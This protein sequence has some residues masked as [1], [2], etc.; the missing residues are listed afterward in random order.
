MLQS[1][2]KTVVTYEVNNMF[3]IKQ[4]LCKHD[5]KPS[6]EEREVGETL[7]WDA[8]PT[9][10]YE[11]NYVCEKCKKVKVSKYIYFR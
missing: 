10:E 8:K 4:R 6:G 11:Q 5:F 2:L 1:A 7:G 9:K 3:N